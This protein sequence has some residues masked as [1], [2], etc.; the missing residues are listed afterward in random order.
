M[1][2]ER[3]ISFI[4][5]MIRAERAGIK[6]Q[7]R[8]VCKPAAKLS[9]VVGIEDPSE[10]GQRPLEVPGSGWFGD[11]EGEGD[12][13][14]CPYGKPGDR[15]WVR[16]HY[17]L[18]QAFDSL[19]PRDVPNRI[20]VDGPPGQISLHYEADGPPDP[21]LFGKFRPAM[22]MCRWMSRTLLEVVSIRVERLQDISEA[23]AKAEGCSP[24]PWVCAPGYSQ[25]T[26]EYREGYCLLWQSIN[27]AGSWDLNPWVW[28]I[29]FKRI[30]P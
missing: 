15:L 28:V 1:T 19:P 4:P 7:T 23:D 6:T 5:E 25:Y 9:E 8:R 2:K 18:A 26:R 22:F 29:E 16:E 27:G 17:R 30:K 11:A 14:F 13:F 20:G 24:A 12:P 21:L 3:P 10:I